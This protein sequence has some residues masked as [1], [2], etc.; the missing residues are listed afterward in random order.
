MKKLICLRREKNRVKN[1]IELLAPVGSMES[2]HAAI[3][4]GADAVY[5]GGRLFNA[6]AGAT[7]FDNEE[8]KEAVKIAHLKGV[9]VYV[10]ANIL[11]D[12]GEMKDILD[13][14]KYLY[15]IDVDAI[16]VQ[17][18]GLLRLVRKLFPLL[19][20][21]ASTQMTINNEYGVKLLEN[22]GVS[23]VVL[24]RETSIDEI[25]RIKVNTNIDLEGFIHGALCVSYSGQCL[26]SSLIGGR[27]G[28]RGTCA[29]P[30]RMAYS[31]VDHN[32]KLVK[33]WDKKYVLSPK[34]LNTIHNIPE[35]I[36]AGISSLKIEGRLKKPEYVATVVKSYRKALDDGINSITNEDIRDIAQMF[37]RGF[38]KGL[39]LGD[40]GKNF[41]SYERPGNQGIVLGQV[42]RA[43]KYKVYV[44]LKEDVKEGD[45][46][47]FE[48]VNGDSKGIKM[49]FDAKAGTNVSIEKPGYILVNTIVYKKTDTSL[50]EKAKASY[51]EETIEYPIDMEIDIH[52]GQSPRLILMYK[53][54]VII[55]SVEDIVEKGERISLTEEKVIAQL[56]KL[57]DTNYYIN[58]VSINLEAG[59]Y[60]PMSILNVLRRKAIEELDKRLKNFNER[61]AL[62]ENDY[63]KTKQ[64]IFKF[65]K[66][67]KEKTKK[68]SIKVDNIN[69]LNSLDL[70]KLNRIYLGFYEDIEAISSK[71]KEKGMEVYIWTDKILYE[72]DLIKLNRIIKPVET[73]VDG[74][75]LSNLGSLMYFKEHFNLKLHGDI[76]LNV[77]NSHTA[78]FLYSLG[79]DSITLSPELNL[80]QIKEITENTNI[81]IESIVYGYLASMTTK[82]CPMALVKGCK[83]DKEC[84]TCNFNKGYGLKD[85]MD[86]VFYMERKQGFTT[87]YNSVPLM[88]LDNLNSV[89][90][91]GV[92]TARLDFTRETEDIKS[93][94]IAYYD[95]INGLIDDSEVRE[96]VEKFR[97]NNKITNGHYFRGVL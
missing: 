15:E 83:D 31:I 76:G 9:R 2:L 63:N 96:F 11:V 81:N 55:S 38:T 33:D 12:Q 57:G 84:T 82:T 87:I 14:I 58:N 40:F 3:E 44:D 92:E 61:I 56:S 29:Q 35:I 90:K 89:Y 27:S 71:L 7:N 95:Y 68:L 13:Y 10:T 26:M 25:K 69:Q 22:E 86:A 37:N 17:D 43:D 51:T 60:L 23:R 74:I 91:S 79:L 1:K 73:I 54:H 66:V 65:D 70:N 59:S 64:D 21:H 34:D 97:F 52:I 41:I 30:C 85:R 72:E 67:K 49:P 80:N 93:I 45:I 24:A 36:Q 19:E 53:N 42:V 47:E 28:N 62:D 20:V 6:R 39:G 4:N 94:Q 88:V 18:L 75:S 5:L 78:E 46:I 48:L 77:F 50:I 32:G 8:L 16:I